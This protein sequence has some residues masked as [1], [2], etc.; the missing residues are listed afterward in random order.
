MLKYCNQ[1]LWRTVKLQFV[2]ITTVWNGLKQFWFNNCSFFKNITD[3]IRMY[4]CQNSQYLKSKWLFSWKICK[5]FPELEI[6]SGQK[7]LSSLLLQNII[8]VV[9]L[10]INAFQAANSSST[11]YDE[12]SKLTGNTAH[13]SDRKRKRDHIERNIMIEGSPIFLFIVPSATV[14]FDW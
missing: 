5:I 4:Y 14:L 2:A 7:L 12:A 6:L 1:E 13:W 11:G 8:R 10:G 9:I 3:L